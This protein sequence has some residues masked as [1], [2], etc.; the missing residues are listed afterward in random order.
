MENMEA[1]NLP[2]G[3]TLTTNSNNNTIKTTILI[4][5]VRTTIIATVCLS[6]YLSFGSKPVGVDCVA[7]NFSRLI[8]FTVVLSAP[9]HGPP[10]LSL[11]PGLG[12]AQVPFLMLVAR[13]RGVVIIT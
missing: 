7:I 13:F 12:L 4:I 11:C 6:I 9:H 5:I 3:R 1:K 10:T 8:L 2:N